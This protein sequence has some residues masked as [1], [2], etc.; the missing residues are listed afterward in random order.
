MS[1]SK[2]KL[3][4]TSE[5]PLNFFVLFFNDEYSVFHAVGYEE[6]PRISDIYSLIEELRD[7]EDLNIGD[8]IFYQKMDIITSE[9]YY[10]MMEN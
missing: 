8:K 2:E 5:F 10:K 1:Q 9:D 4:N 3:E 7:N 6:Y